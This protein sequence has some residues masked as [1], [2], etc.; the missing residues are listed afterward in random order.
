MGLHHKKVT[1]TKYGRHRTLAERTGSWLKKYIIAFPILALALGL[2][3]YGYLAHQH[4]WAAI[5][6]FVNYDKVITEGPVM[7]APGEIL[8]SYRGQMKGEKTPKG[9]DILSGEK[10]LSV[11]Y[12]REIKHFT[13]IGK[14]YQDSI[15]YLREQLSA[16]KGQQPAPPPTTGNTRH[17]QMAKKRPDRDGQKAA[18]TG[19]A[20]S[21][22]PKK[23]TEKV[24]FQ[25][26]RAPSAAPPATYTKVYVNGQQEVGPGTYVRLRLGEGLVCAGGTVAKNTLFYGTATTGAGK[27][28]VT[29]TNIGPCQGPFEL[30]DGDFTDGLVMG[31]TG[32]APQAV[33]DYLYRSAPNHL[34]AL[35]IGAIR[36]V[37]RNIAARK[38]AKRAHIVLP[39]G[40]TLYLKHQ[41]P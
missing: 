14:A 2:G 3:L 12:G 41:A 29:V 23:A 18:T 5:N 32:E 25:T 21:L 28:K 17:R 11:N 22:A 13:D 26:L 1:A 24:H 10:L 7:E 4:P 37:G 20:D 16:L 40:Y 35:P 31:G 6:P 34:R 39:D 8:D 36:E 33:G 27:M 38:R 30:L 9:H 19:Q 15:G